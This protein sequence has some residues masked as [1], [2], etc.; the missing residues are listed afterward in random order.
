MVGIAIPLLDL[1]HRAKGVG[2]TCWESPRV[3][4]DLSDEIRVNHP[5][6]TSGSSLGGEV[7]DH[8]DLYPIEV[9]DILRR[10]PASHDEV[11]AIRVGS[12]DAR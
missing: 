8:G 7:V 6:D 2:P 3:E 11:I 4:A 12:S 5:D 1:H 9:E 10:S